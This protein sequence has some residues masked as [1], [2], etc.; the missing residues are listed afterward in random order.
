VSSTKIATIAVIA[1][2]LPVLFIAVTTGVIASVL[3]GGPPHGGLDTDCAQT[4]Q[5]RTSVAGYQPDQVANAATI[6]AVGKR[7]NVPAQGWVVAITAALAES[8]LHNL[9]YGDR[10]SLG[11][12]QQRPSQGWGTPTQILNPSYSATQFYRHLLALPNWQQM[13]VNDAAQAV[14]RSATPSA[15]APHEP[16]ARA[17]VNTVQT[18]TCT[19]PTTNPQGGDCAR[20]PTSNPDALAAIR[21][22]CA[23][24]GKPYVWGGNGEPG[25]DCSGLTKAAYNAAGIQLPRTAQTQYQ[26]GPL[27]PTS[28]EL[29]PGDLIFFGTPSHVEHVA[30]SLGGTTIL[31][32]PTF[33]QPVQ[34]SDYRTFTNAFAASRPASNWNTPVPAQA[35]SRR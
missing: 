14:Q 19:N 5:R 16:T 25:F 12:F 26:A 11:L 20:T 9:N 34:I 28:T 23:Q 7:L 29:A 15:Y 21:Y 8:G 32:A 24:L 13:S 33:G 17:F 4:G 10:D 3:S 2:F 22:A 35:G 1:F 27:L 6:V 31:H 18:A 30:L